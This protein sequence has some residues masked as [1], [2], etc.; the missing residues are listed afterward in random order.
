MIY[1]GDL[2]SSRNLP[3]K[4]C[5]GL[6][7]GLSVQPT[8]AWTS[9]RLC[10]S[11]MPPE[12]ARYGTDRSGTGRLCLFEVVGASKTGECEEGTTAPGCEFEA[13]ISQGYL[14][15]LK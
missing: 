2:T 8:L 14:R 12:R 11:W 10:L 15:R 5:L 1:K 6:D 9:A 3:V 13:F 4:I 7:S